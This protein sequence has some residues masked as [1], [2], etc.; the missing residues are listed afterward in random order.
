MPHKFDPKHMAKL[1][2]RRKI[3]P[4]EEILLE[5][6]LK[7]GE[8][9]I[10]IGAGSGYFSIPAAEIVGDKGRVI[11]VDNSKE[12][13]DE[14]SSRVDKSGSGNIEIVLSK[15]YDLAVKESMGD[16]V[17]ISTVLHEVEDKIIF[18]NEIKKV[19]K[20]K[21]NLAIVEWIKKPME[22]GPPIHDRID[23]SEITELLK[24]LGFHDIRQKD[25]NNYFY[26]V[27]AVK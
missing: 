8:I 26:F 22:K 6:G 7:A 13:I 2:E 18:L 1:E 27:T 9:M 17:F 10:D 14:L 4:P 21:G 24:Q 23:A 20:P 12:M 19:M 15:E 5:L 16:F 11:A 3:L 25:Y